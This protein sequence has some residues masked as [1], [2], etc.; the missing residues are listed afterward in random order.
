[1]GYRVKYL[2]AAVGLMLFWCAC[3]SLAGGPAP[4]EEIINGACRGDVLKFACHERR[5]SG[6]IIACL[7]DRWDELSRDCKIAMVNRS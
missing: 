3:E 4:N 1:M 5:T 6:E 7:W 2:L